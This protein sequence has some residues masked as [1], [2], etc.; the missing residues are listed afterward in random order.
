M[1]HDQIL[2]TLEELAFEAFVAELDPPQPQRNAGLERLMAVQ[3][4]WDVDE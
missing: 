4:P 1:D 3:A 2:F